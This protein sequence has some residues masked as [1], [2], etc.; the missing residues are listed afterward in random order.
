MIALVL[1]PLVLLAEGQSFL[2]T[3]TSD[4]DPK[5]HCLY[6]RE[7][8]AITWH[9]NSEGNPETT[10]DTEFS[11]M[12]KAFG[13]WQAQMDACGSLSFKQGNLTGSRTIGYDERAETNENI[14]VFRQRRCDDMVNGQPVAPAA[15]SCWKDET[16]NNKYDCWSYASG[17]IAITTTSFNPKSGFIYDSDIELNTPGYIF[18][19]VDSPPCVLRMYNQGCVA[20]DV[21]NTLTHEIGHL[22]GLAHTPMAGSIMNP[23][24]NPGETSK[25]TIDPGTQDFICRVYAKGRPAA[26]CPVLL[27]NGS[28]TIPKLTDTL[29]NDLRGCAAAPGALALG[30]AALLFARRRSG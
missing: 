20:T 4:S 12:Q 10:G 6:W 28:A 19:A 21:Q 8:T 25:R 24:A 26:D 3:R 23:T 22:V 14:V 2:R 13:A 9:A 29:G 5:A 30:L 18:T 16:C 1:A 27:P 17:A 15:D 7:G 11:A